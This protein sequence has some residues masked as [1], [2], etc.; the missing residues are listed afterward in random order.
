[1]GCG[2]ATLRQSTVFPILWIIRVV[3]RT[4]VVVPTHGFP[5]LWINGAMA[6]DTPWRCTIVLGAVH[7]I[8]D[9]AQPHTSLFG[10]GKMVTALG[11]VPG[12][13]T[14]VPSGQQ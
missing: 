6:S 7:P 2:G 8:T 3:H 5:L 13:G 1:M 14:A 10:R 4:G 9:G 12:Q 11:A